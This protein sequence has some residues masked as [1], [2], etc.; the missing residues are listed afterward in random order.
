QAL[1]RIKFQTESTI[2]PV[3]VEHDKLLKLVDR[4][5]RSAA[6]QLA[7]LV[8]E[9]LRLDL[10]SDDAPA[11]LDTSS[12]VDDAPVVK[13]LQ[14]VLLDAIHAGASDLHFEPYERF[15]RIRLRVDGE[16]REF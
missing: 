4:L 10:A 6:Q 12:E 11:G 3:V 15:Y 7:D 14:K 2:D 1:D 8:D 16:L 13:F 9:S 5:G